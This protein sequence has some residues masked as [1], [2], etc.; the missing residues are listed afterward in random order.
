[1]KSPKEDNFLKLC[2][3]D[4]SWDLADVVFSPLLDNPPSVFPISFSRSL[5]FERFPTVF[6][7]VFFSLG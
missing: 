1:M 5:Y 3:S 6:K 2:Y 4:D 7:E